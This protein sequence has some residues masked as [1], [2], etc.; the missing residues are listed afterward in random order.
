MHYRVLGKTGIRVSEIGIGCASFWGKKL[1]SEDEARRL[2]HVAIDQG[3][4]FFDTA[5]SYSGGN[6]EAR[7]GRALADLR[8]TRHDL[9]VSTKIGSHTN[10]IGR[11]Y[12]D[13]RPSA[14]R[15]SVEMSLRRLNLETL[16]IL[17]LHG[18]DF[19]EFNTDGLL[20]ELSKLKCEGKFRHLGINSFESD[21][22]EHV[23][24]LPQFEIVMIDYNILKPERAALLEKL[25][26]ANLG[27]LAARPLAGAAFSDTRKPSRSI[28]DMW[29]SLRAW[30]H[31][32]WE[33]DIAPQIHFINRLAGWSGSQVAL[34][35]VLQNRHVHCAVFGTTRMEH[36]LENLAV[37]DMTLD[38]AVSEMIETTI[39]AARGT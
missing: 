33:S 24:T 14:V 26:N 37:T 39:R 20:H 4:T 30:R 28:R 11:A 7:L 6:A 31:H 13:F 38:P 5:S 3:V 36:L 9:I 15:R 10:R 19:D 1:F 32:K 35:W 27:I 23:L 17:L 18:P 16:P 34:S 29:Y 12:G 2:I 21:M 25:F 22:I 8:S